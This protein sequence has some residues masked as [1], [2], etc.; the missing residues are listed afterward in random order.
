[1]NNGVE[2]IDTY[3]IPFASVLWTNTVSC[4]F[5]LRWHLPLR[6]E[7]TDVVYD[8]VFFFPKGVPW[9]WRLLVPLLKYSRLG[10]EEARWIDHNHIGTYITFIGT[11]ERIALFPCFTVSFLE[12]F[13]TIVFFLFIMPGCST[14]HFVLDYYSHYLVHIPGP[15]TTM[16]HVPPDLL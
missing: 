12:V 7:L 15:F 2:G 6:V 9:I 1:M 14:F 4:T 11:W 10:V 3:C 16:S 8:P 13:L 5:P